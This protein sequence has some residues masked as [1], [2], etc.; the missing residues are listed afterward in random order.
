MAS[1][2]SFSTAS[3]S[4]LDLDL[5]IDR[6]KDGEPV[7]RLPPSTTILGEPLK[8]SVDSFLTVDGDVEEVRTPSGDIA[9]PTGGERARPIEDCGPGVA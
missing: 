5:G 6:I 4:S 7:P 3:R 9:R 8:G 1:R 2:D